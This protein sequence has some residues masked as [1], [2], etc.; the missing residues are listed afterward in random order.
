MTPELRIPTA[1]LVVVAD[2]NK[3]LFLRN[4]GTAQVPDLV[5]EDT[6]EQD[7]PPDREQ[8]SDRAGRR[9]AASTNQTVR[10]AV[11][12]TDRHDLEESRFSARVAER[13]YRDPPTGAFDHLILVAPPTALGQLRR[14]L[15]DSVSE[16]VLGEIPKTLTQHGVADIQKVLVAG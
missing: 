1:T 4:R 6:M 16:R 3:A 8:T 11:E 13:L 15:H 10:G 14:H 12:Q 9:A 7:N 2:G 5:V